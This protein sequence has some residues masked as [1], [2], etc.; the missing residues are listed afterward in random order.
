MQAC[1]I[2]NKHSELLGIK[3]H[4]GNTAHLPKE[5][6][7]T[8]RKY[9]LTKSSIAI[10]K[11]KDMMHIVDNIEFKLKSIRDEE[12]DI[13]RIKSTWLKPNDINF[14]N[15]KQTTKKFQTKQDTTASGFEL[16]Y[17]NWVSPREETPHRIAVF[18]DEA[19]SLSDEL[20]NE[21][22]HLERI[23]NELN[24]KSVI[25]NKSENKSN[26]SQSN[27]SEERKDKI[28][29]SKEFK[30]LRN[31]MQK[32]LL[33]SRAKSN[34]ASDQSKE[35]SRFDYDPKHKNESDVVA[36][37]QNLPKKFRRRYEEMLLIPR[38]ED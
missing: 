29:I 11:L 23:Q 22:L 30:I 31:E 21:K 5:F 20:E 12:F 38:G 19:V 16:S 4:L 7:S 26:D 6:M 34:I 9:Y 1:M 18:N 14:D 24:F 32:D 8:E 33:S 15:L 10:N 27:V 3:Y 17:F 37:Y 2:N 13:D 36:S 25:L 28:S 35:I